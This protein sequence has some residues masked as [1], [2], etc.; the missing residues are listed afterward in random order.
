MPNSD[1]VDRIVRLWERKQDHLLS[2]ERRRTFAERAEVHELASASFVV[3]LRSAQTVMDACQGRLLLVEW[4]AAAR[5]LAEAERRRAEA[6]R[7]LVEAERQ[8]IEAEQRAIEAEY[9]A[10]GSVDLDEV[11]EERA[12]VAATMEQARI[13]KREDAWAKSRARREAREV[14]QRESQSR[15]LSTLTPEEREANL[16][17][18]RDSLRVEATPAASAPHVPRVPAAQ[19]AD[20]CPSCNTLPDP[21]GHCRC[22]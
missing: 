6:D 1:E 19:E 15:R 9:E 18:W 11:R 4:L 5:H 22:S 14:A 20:L 2:A 17:E 16:Q 8:A 13:A 7:K 21:L 12:A 3:A 10:A